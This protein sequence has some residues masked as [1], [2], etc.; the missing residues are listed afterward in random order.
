MKKYITDIN[1]NIYIEESNINNIKNKNIIEVNVDNIISKYI[2]MGSALTE[3]SAYNYHLLNDVN[4]K[5]F[6]K[7]MFTKEGLNYNFGRISIGS[8]DF[9]LKTYQY[10]KRKDL[11]DFSIDHDKQYTIPFIKDILDYK[12]L[13]LIASPWSPPGVFKRFGILRYG[14][15]LKKDYYE[16]YSLYIK[17]WLD[18]YSSNGINVNYLTMQNEPEARQP[19]ESCV[20]SLDEQKA[21][22]YNHLLNKL[23]NQKVLLWD[24]NKDD[25][26]HKFKSLYKDDDKVAGIGFHYYTDGNYEELHKIREKNKDILMINTEMCCGYSKYN[27]KEWIKDAEY[28]L[29]DII[30]DFN[31]GINAYLDW[32]ILLDKNGG[33]TYINNKVKSAVIYDNKSFIKT[34]IYYYLY[35]ISHFLDDTYN[36]VET[37]NNKHLYIA[38]FS[39]KDNIVIIVLNTSS[40]SKEYT[41]KVNNQEIKDSINTHSIITYV[42][43]R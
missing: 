39:N 17:K 34:P 22:L 43:D 30:N 8:N 15:K 7:T 11:K 5:E 25:L 1:N 41:I 40:N 10:T 38:S 9:S 19:W 4:K 28:Y 20:F 14:I 35:H 3:S 42:L 32:N 6:I 29:K 12:N 24:H 16:E 27:E 37:I 13:N 36:V 33:P 18:S 31:N 23:D 26:Y 21:F 2:G